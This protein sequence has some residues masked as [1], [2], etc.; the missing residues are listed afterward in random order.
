MIQTYTSTNS[1]TTSLSFAAG[2]GVQ[3]PLAHLCSLLPFSKPWLI[4]SAKWH[5][6]LAE[7]TNLRRSL[8]ATSFLFTSA[9][10]FDIAS[11]P[12]ACVLR[13]NSMW[14]LRS[15]RG[16]ESSVDKLLNDWGY[17][18]LRTAHRSRGLS[19]RTSCIRP[20]GRRIA[21][22]SLLLEYWYEKTI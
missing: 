1:T 7:R 15:K 21:P 8:I 5:F 6:M 2:K 10:P 9:P 12:A 16:W 11:P 14:S 19:S 20:V 18:V 13:S 17:V 3:V 4:G 22:S